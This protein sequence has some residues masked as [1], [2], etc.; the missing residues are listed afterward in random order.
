LNIPIVSDTLKKDPLEE[1]NSDCNKS[2]VC[3]VCLLTNL[4]VA[5]SQSYNIKLGNNLPVNAKE[6][7]DAFGKINNKAE[8]EPFWHVYYG[9]FDWYRLW[10]KL[11]EKAVM[12]EMGW[13]YN[14]EA[15]K[16]RRNIRGIGFKVASNAINALRRQ[17]NEH[18]GRNSGMNIT[19]KRKST[20]ITDEN[21]YIN[22]DLLDSS[23]DGYLHNRCLLWRRKE[24][25]SVRT[26]KRKRDWYQWTRVRVQQK[27]VKR[28]SQRQL[29]SLVTPCPNMI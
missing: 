16:L 12:H 11:L 20:E 2:F 14:E 22:E 8:G 27:R 25:K 1:I 26:T 5:V 29:V 18:G 21:R 9:F 13:K 23:N 17:T 10:Q 15:M 4:L 19:I 28:K 6:I 3:A 24:V 7:C